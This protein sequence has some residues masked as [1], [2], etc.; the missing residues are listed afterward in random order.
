MRSKTAYL[1]LALALLL[2]L[3]ACKGQADEQ[4]TQPPVIPTVAPTQE[5]TPTPTPPIPYTDVSEDADYYNAVVWAYKNGIAS[6]GKTFEPDSACTR[7]Q[8]IT[9]LWRAMGSPEPQITECPIS[10]V[11]P[12]DWFYTP[13]L[14]AYESGISTSSTFNPGNPCSNAEALTF[15]WRAEGEPA[16]AVHN[17][18]VALAASGAY[19]ERPAAWAETNGVL[20][21]NFDPSAP[22]S[23]AGLMMYLHW[24]TEEWTFDEEDKAL[25]AEYEQIISDTQLYEVHGFGLVYADYV[26]VDNDGKVELLTVAVD[27]DKGQAT[28]A[29]YANVDGH[30]QKAS[31]MSFEMRIGTHSSEFLLCK[32]DGQLYLCAAGLYT[33]S[34]GAYQCNTSRFYRLGTDAIVLEHDLD[35]VEEYNFETETTSRTYTDSDKKISEGEFNAVLQKFT[36]DRLLYE[37]ESWGGVIHISNRGILPSEDEYRLNYWEGVNPFYAAVLKGDFSAFAGNYGNF[38]LN[39]DGSITSS[40]PI[41]ITNR[42]PISVTI[43]EEGRISCVLIEKNRDGAEESYEICPIGLGYESYYN[44]QMGEDIPLDKSKI[45]IFY[46]WR[47]SES[48]NNS[49][50]CKVS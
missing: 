19:Y 42:K 34:A 7:G 16:A 41:F 46:I 45:Q 21:S 25:Q 17:S 24:L 30:A 29:V 38:T 5:P 31:E 8:V 26:D 37:L 35:Y 15:L 1:C 12:S 20:G 9:F 11:A 3:A 47:G 27:D 32:T 36:D 18:P 22:C 14:W 33:E 2:S 6:D 43:T 40:S 48:Y 50:Y 13:V 10:D 44:G 28:A 23:R 39:A 49:G 4:D